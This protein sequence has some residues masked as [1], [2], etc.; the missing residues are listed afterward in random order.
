MTVPARWLVVALFATIAVCRADAQTAAIGDV[1]STADADHFDALRLRGGALIRYRSPF[2]YAGVAAQTTFYT[3][4]GWNQDA[5]A[6]LGLWRNQRRE[7]LAGTIGEAGLVRVSGRT[8]LIG[9]GTWSLRPRARTG[10]E[11]LATSDLVETQRAL[12]RATAY[13]FVAASIERQFTERFTAIGLAGYQHFTDRNERFHL[14]GR[15]IWLLIPEHGIS[16]QA[17]WRQYDSQQIDVGGAYFNPRR[18]RQ[19]EAGLAIRKR[20]AGLL[21]SGNVTGGREE[22]DG[23][24][25]HATV[26]ADVRAEGALG[27]KMRVMVRAS[28]NR[29]A[30]FAAADGYWYRTVGVTVVVPF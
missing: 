11:L 13:Q 5:R 16:A 19:W 20:H 15:L 23:D 2:E 27:K 26:L 12:E 25:G 24:A 21:W 7:T 8:R 28:Y 30:G 17:R 1:S 10:I 29:S 22:I 3:R 6:I 14:R 9:D 4:S 18:Y